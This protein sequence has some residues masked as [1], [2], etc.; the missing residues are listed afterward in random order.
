M[1]TASVLERARKSA[2]ALMTDECTVVRPIG[3][4]TDPATGEVK[5][6]S[7]Q[8]YV[9]RC[10]VQTSGGLAAENTEGGIVEALGAV[11]PVWSMY[12]HFPYGTTGLL[13]GDVC[14][15]TEAADPNLKGRKLRLLNM[16][17][18]KTHSTACRWN[19]K[20][21]GNSNE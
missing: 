1:L 19:V 12:V 13:P 5:P 6:A 18:E 4:V 9:G 15:I 2:E 8:V 16:Q 7:T 14:E 17:S 11:T 3:S 21:V 10:K 20:E